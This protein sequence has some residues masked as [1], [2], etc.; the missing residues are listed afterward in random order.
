MISEL[1]LKTWDDLASNQDTLDAMVIRKLVAE[2]RRLKAQ[3]A[4]SCRCLTLSEHLGDGCVG[5]WHYE[6]G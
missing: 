2:V 6:Q 4:S 1:Q 3:M 5:E